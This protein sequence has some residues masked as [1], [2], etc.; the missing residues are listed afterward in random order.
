MHILDRTTHH[1]AVMSWMLLRLESP[2]LLALACRM[3]NFCAWLATCVGVRVFTDQREMLRQ[4]PRPY[5]SSP[6][7]N[8]LFIIIIEKERKRKLAV[9]RYSRRVVQG[10]VAIGK[11]R[12]CVLVRQVMWAREVIRCEKNNIIIPRISK[13]A[14]KITEKMKNNME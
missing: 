13:S 5:F 8:S 1:G 14:P 6:S 7:R 11:S 4:S 3:K 10:T 9:T 2:R 12:A